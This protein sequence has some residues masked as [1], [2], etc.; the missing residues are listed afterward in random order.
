M[1]NFTCAVVA[2]L[3]SV[4]GFASECELNSRWDILNA[5]YA[6][7]IGI[8]R[9]GDALDIRYEYTHADGAMYNVY[10]INGKNER[11]LCGAPELSDV[12]TTE[13]G[14]FTIGSYP[15]VSCAF[16]DGGELKQ[17][18]AALVKNGSKT[19]QE[20]SQ[21]FYGIQPNNQWFQYNG[22]ELADSCYSSNAC[23]IYWNVRSLDDVINEDDGS[24]SG[25][26]DGGTGGGGTT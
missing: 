21:S 5:D 16:Y 9:V 6:S 15:R 18:T 3:S 1:K 11:L 8:V 26:N 4:N 25:G 22:S 2:L 24:G 14:Q 7:Q 23:A 10:L 17:F 13:L 20:C 19:A 12:I